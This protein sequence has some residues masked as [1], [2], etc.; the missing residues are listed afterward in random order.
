MQLQTKKLSTQLGQ[1][2]ITLKNLSSEFQGIEK[3][4]K[5]ST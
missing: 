4:G 2:M 1:E 3:E 5:H